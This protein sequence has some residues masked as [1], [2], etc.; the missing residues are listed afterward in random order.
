MRPSEREKGDKSIPDPG[1]FAVTD[2]VE[3]VRCINA[4]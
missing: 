3:P 1:A 4:M 2:P